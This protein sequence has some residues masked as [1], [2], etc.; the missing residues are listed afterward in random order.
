MWRRAEVSAWM[1]RHEGDKSKAIRNR[2]I[3]FTI[4]IDLLLTSRVE[5]SYA[6]VVP[7]STF[8][9]ETA[10]MWSPRPSFSFQCTFRSSRLSLPATLSTISI[11]SDFT[12]ARYIARNSVSPYSVSRG[13]RDWRTG[14][15]CPHETDYLIIQ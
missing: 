7:L 2:R 10:H 1:D 11:Y 12:C 14:G 6:P 4:H 8:D 9:N 5:A 13:A 3:V 15:P